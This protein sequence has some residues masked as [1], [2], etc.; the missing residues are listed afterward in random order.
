M[1]NGTLCSGTS[2]VVVI[3]NYG[4]GGSGVTLAWGCAK[5]VA[6]LVNSI[7]GATSS[8]PNYSLQTRSAGAQQPCIQANS[9]SAGSDE[10]LPIAYPEDSLVTIRPGDATTGSPPLKLH[11]RTYGDPRNPALLVVNGIGDRRGP[12]REISLPTPR[13]CRI[14]RGLFFQPRHRWKHADGPRGSSHR[15]HACP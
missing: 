2:D 5:D 6:N 1:E 9:T 7:L 15:V 10:C 8:G 4:H 14:F 11:V 13:I 3:G 12:T